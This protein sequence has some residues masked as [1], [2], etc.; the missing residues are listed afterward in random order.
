ML[1]Q[2]VLS[3]P[4][5]TG[6]LMTVEPSARAPAPIIERAGQ[7]VSVPSTP[8]REKKNAEDEYGVC[9]KEPTLWSVCMRLPRAAGEHLAICWRWSHAR[10]M[11]TVKETSH[12][13]H[14]RST[15]EAEQRGSVLSGGESWLQSRHCP[16]GTDCFSFHPSFQFPWL[17]PQSHPGVTL[18]THVAIRHPDSASVFPSVL[19]VA[20]SP[21]I[22][23]QRQVWIVPRRN[24]VT[25]HKATARVNL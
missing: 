16:R 18:P 21:G 10:W 1:W 13:D 23:F 7:R 12:S 8:G 2:N 5:W 4:T 22:D 17:T 20:R 6:L 25:I 24:Q 9:T 15:Q 19:Q 14:R 3:P 11:K